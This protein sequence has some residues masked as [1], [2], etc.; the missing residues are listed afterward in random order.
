MDWLNVIEIKA[1]M[2]SKSEI[3]K[4]CSLIGSQNPEEIDSH[5]VFG[6][7]RSEGLNVPL[8]LLGP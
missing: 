4:I 1:I 2:I 5:C 3:V 6:P 7:F 8:G